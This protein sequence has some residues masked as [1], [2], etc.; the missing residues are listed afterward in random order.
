MSSESKLAIRN[1]G[2]TFYKNTPNQRIALDRVNLTLHAGDFATV[3]GGNGAGKSTLLNAIAGEV[4]ADEGSI[5]V[6][7]I[8]VTRLPTHERAAW[9]S[10][11]FQDPH[12][13]TASTLSIEE[14]LAVADQR[15]NVRKL[16]PGLNKAKKDIYRQRLASFG[17][18]LESRMGAKV[19]LLSGG[20]RQSLSLLMAV[21]RVPELLLLDE[22]TAALDPR[23][24]EIVMEATANIIQQERLTTLMVTHNMH[25]AIKYG[26]RLIMMREGQIILDVSGP[27]RDAL[28]V[29]GLV[30]RFHLTNDSQL[31]QA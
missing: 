12:V 21:L 3:I 10:R 20:Q 24:A 5:H 2:R 18:G 26:N 22:H 7:D 6:K 15:G 13:G 8:D 16:L 9:I 1:L 25:Q 30:E 11:V 28:T 23:T 4:L 19:G 27:D 17:L 31:L 14:N 29:P